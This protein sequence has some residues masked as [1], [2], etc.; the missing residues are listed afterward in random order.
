GHLG[1]AVDGHGRGIVDRLQGLLGEVLRGGRRLVLAAL[2]GGLVDRAVEHLVGLAV[3]APDVLAVVDEAVLLGAVEEGQLLPLG[4][5]GRDAQ[6]VGA[7]GQLR[8]LGGRVGGGAVPALAEGTGG[9][10]ALQPSEVGQAEVGGDLHGAGQL[11][12]VRLRDLLDELC[13]GDVR[14]VGVTGTGDGGH[15]PDGRGRH[16]HH[17]DR[18]DVPGGPAAA[19]AGVAGR[20]RGRPVV[21]CVRCHV[22]LTSWSAAA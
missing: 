18:D 22:C 1:G 5:V 13:G 10:A 3:V 6:G 4:A 15:Q 9:E 11:L 20:L 17:R 19:P 2:P 21:G 16:P 7:G 8:Q 14:Q 12:H